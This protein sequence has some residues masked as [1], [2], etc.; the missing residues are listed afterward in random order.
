M[1]HVFYAGTTYIVDCVIGV[2]S[3]HT[4]IIRWLDVHS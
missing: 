3:G 2:S 4:G 1:I